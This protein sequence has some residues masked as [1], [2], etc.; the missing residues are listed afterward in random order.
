MFSSRRCSFVVPRIGTID[1]FCAHRRL[2]RLS[3]RYRVGIR[4][5]SELSG[6]VVCN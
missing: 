1:G 2:S 4:W 6:R 5:K 3:Q